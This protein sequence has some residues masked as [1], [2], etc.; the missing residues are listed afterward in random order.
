MIDGVP[1]SDLP[2]DSS[3]HEDLPNRLRVHSLARILGTTSRRVLD[4]LSELDGRIR[5]AHSSVD[6]ADAV[7]VRDL[8][9]AVPA[10]SAVSDVAAVFVF[11]TAGQRFAQLL[12][13]ILTGLGLF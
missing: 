8:L 12:R 7:R 11:G 10:A 3:R 5:S 2:E 13:L 6:R 4:A 9:A 1:S